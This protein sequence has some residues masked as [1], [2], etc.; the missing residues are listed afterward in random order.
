VMI[1]NIKHIVCCLI[2][3]LT[4][5]SCSGPVA[6][7]GS[8][9][10]V[11]SRK[12]AGVVLDSAGLP[13]ANALVKIRPSIYVIDSVNSES[14]MSSH[15]VRNIK[16]GA[17]GS[18]CFDSILADEYC[19]DISKNDSIGAVS[20]FRINDS[21]RDIRLSSIKLEPI[22]VIDGTI[23]VN[24]VDSAD[25]FLQVFGTDYSRKAN[26]NGYFSM[27]IPRGRHTMYF[28]A[29][30]P[31]DTLKTKPVDHF[32]LTFDITESYKYMGDFW[33][34]PPPPDTCVDFSCDSIILRKALDEMHL[35]STDVRAVATVENN[36]IVGLNFRRIPIFYLSKYVES[37]TE[38]RTLDLGLTRIFDV[39][40]TIGML[41]KLETL[42]L[43]SNGLKYLPF[44]I[45]YLT[46]LKSLDI[47][48]N[49][50]SGLPPGF[51]N[52]KLEYLDLSKNT[53]C[54]PDSVFVNWADMYDPDWRSAQFC[55]SKY[56]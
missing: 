12:V 1:I 11:S 24:G 7:G 27:S 23:R 36:R 42:K 9:T 52:L 53:F 30:K 22:A 32:E 14:F 3:A 35:D 47:N 21:E 29:Y 56:P 37:L 15:Y 49:F 19:L 31:W 18:F 46:S 20:Q 40:P 16:T 55:P 50:I 26:T 28:G 2:A 33:L 8:D 41:Q 5:F 13:V 34:K 25:C 17:D 43:D 54:S 39:L 48:S 38:L 44:S 4:L 10:E 45:I 6:G 51:Q